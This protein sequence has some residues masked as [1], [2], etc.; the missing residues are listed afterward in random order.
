MIRRLLGVL[1]WFCL[2][3]AWTWPTAIHPIAA[4]PG[5]AHTDVWENLWTLWFVATRLAH[6]QSPLRVDGLLDTVHGGSLWPADPLSAVIL[7][8]LTL[9]AGPTVSWSLLVVLHM[10]LRGWLGARIGALFAGSAGVAAGFGRDAAGWVCGA[11]L[12]L[13]SMALADVHNGASETLGDTWCLA[14]VA[15]ALRYSP[16]RARSASGGSGVSR[17]WVVGAGALLA[18]SAIA[19]WYGGVSAFLLWAALGLRRREDPVASR[20]QRRSFL[21]AAVLGVTLAL[22]VAYEARAVSTAADNVVGIKDPAE[23]ARLRRN[24]GPA[25]PEAYVLPAPFRSP[26]FTKISRY[27]E[28]YWHC[29]Y[30]GW[31]AIGLS[32]ASL[33]PGA[34]T[35][36]RWPWAVIP[37]SIALSLGPVLTAGG[38]VVILSGRRAIPLPY[39]LIEKLPPFNALSLLWKLGWAAEVAVALLAGLGLARLL[40][41]R[42]PRSAALITALVLPAIAAE[43]RFMAPTRN[44]PDHV[45]ATLPAPILALRDAPPGMVMTWPLIGGLPTLYE[46]IGHGKTIAASLNFPASR[47]AW[48]VTRAVPKGAAATIAAAHET[49]IRYVVLHLTAPTNGDESGLQLGNWGDFPV[50]AADDRVRVLQLY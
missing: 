47:G 23:L 15:F 6:G 37:A 1:P 13:S 38:S 22:P 9:L 48:T 8:P 20:I 32:L 33:L 39:F 35:R 26:D 2:A 5:S 29:P 3:V 46:Q 25:D 43:A 21:V 41:G 28:D 27:G 31:V 40:A 10:T 19:H 45:D 30:L 14:V 44:L 42:G 16:S 12:A 34:R 7:T 24:I 18:L 36:A 50:L 49:G 4:T 17:G 11:V